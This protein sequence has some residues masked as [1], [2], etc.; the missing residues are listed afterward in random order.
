MNSFEAY[1]KSTGLK[2]TQGPRQ[3]HAIHAYSLVSEPTYL[4][5]PQTPPD[6]AFREKNQ[7]TS[8]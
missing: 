3:R 4:R 7:L 6:G 5:V 2:L 8:S 1:E